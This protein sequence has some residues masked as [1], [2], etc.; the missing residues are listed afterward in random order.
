MARLKRVIVS[1]STKKGE[2]YEAGLKPVG[3]DYIIRSIEFRRD[4]LVSINHG[5][6]ANSAHYL[7]TL[8]NP[9]NDKDI[10]YKIILYDS[11][12]S[13]MFV[14]VSEESDSKNSGKEALV[15]M[16]RSE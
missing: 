14:E 16:K 2:L 10:L 4:G 3:S 6:G 9:L 15:Q 11:I 1:V 8:E 7:V 13:I 5:G 12:E